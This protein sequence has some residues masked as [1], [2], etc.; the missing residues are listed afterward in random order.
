MSRY[1]SQSLSK[2]N[3]WLID[4]TRGDAGQSGAFTRFTSDAYG[5]Y[6]PVFSPEGDRIVFISTRSGASL[7]QKLTSGVKN[8]ELLL[9]SHGNTAPS[10]WSPNGRFL[11]YSVPNEKA[12][13]EIRI[14]PM[15]GSQK[16]PMLFPGTE[17]N[18]DSAQFSPDGRSIAYQSD[19]SG[20]YEIYVRA[21]SLDSD[22]KPEATEKHP[23]SSGGGTSAHWV[24]GGKELIYVS[25]DGRTIMSTQITTKPTFHSSTAGK[26]FQLP[27]GL[28]GSLSFAVTG[29]GKR[30]LAEVPVGESGPRQFTVVLNWQAGLKK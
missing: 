11:L 17:F 27:V 10:S 30:F 13:N 18:E 22:G 28:M 5:D 6:V 20:R 29:D 15:D 12:K 14:L 2:A 9:K 21:F 3:L 25:S 16:N 26:L 19:E 1:D 4:L 7:Y 23:I 8:E 24:E